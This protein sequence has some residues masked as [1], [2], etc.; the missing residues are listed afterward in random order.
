[1]V[2]TGRGLAVI[3]GRGGGEVVKELGFDEKD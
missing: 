2:D 1:M 3:W